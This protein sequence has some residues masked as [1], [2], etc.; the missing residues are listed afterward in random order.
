MN[1]KKKT[2]WVTLGSFALVIGLVAVSTVI[3]AYAA[4][5][6][7]GDEPVSDTPSSI[8]KDEQG[9]SEVLAITDNRVSDSD[10]I[11]IIQDGGVSEPTFT[12]QDGTVYVAAF[13][14]NMTENNITV[15]VIEFVTS[16]N[17]ERVNELGLTER[18]MPDG[19]YIYNPEQETVIWELNEQTVYTFID[20][21]GDFTGPDD[22]KV[23]TTM[24]TEEFHR[25]IETYDDAA[26][27]M[28]FFFQVEDG[29]VKM[30]LEKWFA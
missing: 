13:L 6:I 8:T 24:N 15:D 22:S 5:S 11:S 27:G 3:G 18:D 25:Y 28:P 12:D 26:P 29:V 16:D 30:V 2:I 1:F 21:Y 17:A 19:Y 14:K 7:T 20:W 9:E 23:Y 10:D 4:T